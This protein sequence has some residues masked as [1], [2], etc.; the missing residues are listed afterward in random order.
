MSEYVRFFEEIGGD[1]VRVP[2]GFAIT[3]DAYRAVLDEAGAWEPLHDALE[4]LAPSDVADVAVAARSFATAEDRPQAS[5]AG[6]HETYLNVKG[7]HS[8]LD[9][10]RR[11]FASLFTDRAV[12]YRIDQGFDHFKLALSV[13]V[14]K[15]V[16]SDLA[17]SG[18]MFSLGTDSGSRDVVFITGSYGLGENVVQGAVDPD[19]F[20]VLEP[21]YER[22][23]VRC[24]AGRWA[25]KP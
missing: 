17:S 20:Y 3:S 14:M 16:R 19:E 2:N 15:M 7:G 21:T 24:S 12:H 18:V 23:G 13:G 9:A 6:Q 22:A 25:T 4:G 1:G 8:L 5:F 10:C 11:R